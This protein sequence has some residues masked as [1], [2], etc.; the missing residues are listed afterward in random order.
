VPARQL[1]SLFHLRRHAA[2]PGGG[3][4]NAL[5]ACC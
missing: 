3:N 2:I 4:D 1:D 5:R